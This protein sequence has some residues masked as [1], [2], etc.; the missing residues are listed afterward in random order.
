MDTPDL[1]ADA[2]QR[3]LQL[4]KNTLADFSEADMLVRPAPGANHAAWQLGHLALSEARMLGAASPGTTVELSAGFAD[5]FSRK[6]STSDDA[7]A[8]PKKA[9][10][11][12]TFA[13][14]RLAAVEW[15][16]G[17]SAADLDRPSP[18]GVRGFAPTIGAMAT[19]LPEH[20]AMH[21]G[22][23]QVIRRVLGKPVLF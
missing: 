3:S 14:V 2:L 7:A 15:A 4:V 11:I 8:F 20:T 16:R 10:I 12:E 9:E 5:A 6:T 18:E 22:Q 13:K 21:L 17:L 23:F 19:M 1:L